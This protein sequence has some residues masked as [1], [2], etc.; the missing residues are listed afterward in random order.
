[1]WTGNATR[2]RRRSGGLG[3]AARSFCRMGQSV[4][5]L[6]DLGCGIFIECGSAGSFRDWSGASPSRSHCIPRRRGSD[7]RG[8]KRARR[9]TKGDGMRLKDQ[10]AVITGGAQGL[11]KRSPR[12]LLPKAPN[13]FFP[14]LMTP[15]FRR[16][17][18]KSARKR[19]W[20][21]WCERE[22]AQI[23]GLRKARRCVA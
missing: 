11:A 4:E 3:A 21:L 5:S 23:A 19:T 16:P 10:I 12:C 18:R 9:H 14:I 17:R 8:Q 22:V 15:W 1:M 7:R 20:R 13:S 6:R 2:G